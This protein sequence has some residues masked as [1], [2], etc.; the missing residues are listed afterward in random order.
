MCECVCVF[1]CV[2]DLRYVKEHRMY[3]GQVTGT[4]M[5]VACHLDVEGGSN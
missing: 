1:G 4:Y 5:H 2:V 3:G